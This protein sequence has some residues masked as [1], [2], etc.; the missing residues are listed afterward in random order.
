MDL[1]AEN[2][3]A[4]IQR[5]A[6]TFALKAQNAEAAGGEAVIIFN[7]GN[8]PTRMDLIV[9]TL[10][11]D[12]GV[13][14]PVVGASFDQGFALAQEGA[15][16]SVKVR[17]SGT[18]TDSNV[19]AELP[20]KNR[21]NIVMAGAH[22]DSVTEG[23]GINDNGSGSAALLETALMMQN[24]R[25]QNTVRFAWW[26]SEE[27]GLVGSTQYVEGLSEEDVR[28]SR[29]TSTTTWSD[30]PTTSSWCTTQTS[31]P[32]RLR[33][34]C[35]RA[36]R[37]SRISMSRTTPRSVGLRRLGVLGPQR[38]PGIHRGRHPRGWTVHRRRG[39]QD[40]GAGD[41]SASCVGR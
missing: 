7:Q 8:D 11:P 14:I 28:R 20:G 37:P 3:I 6:C 15:T 18:R 10:G 34:R 24:L 12:S 39:G 26:A 16:A 21:N 13:T 41:Q 33:C 5:G 17:E 4:L 1:S 9:G 38:L 36:Q 23:P 29:S 25:P 30:L 27:L 32:S 2:D 19:I 31:R 35:R 40:R 22:L